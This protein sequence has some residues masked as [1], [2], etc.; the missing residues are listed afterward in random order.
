[1]FKGDIDKESVFYDLILTPLTPRSIGL[2]L[3]FFK[4][5]AGIA[6]RVE[7][8]IERFQ[9]QLNES[10]I[11][12]TVKLTKNI[13]APIKSGISQQS[14][15]NA[16]INIFYLKDKVVEHRVLHERFEALSVLQR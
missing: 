5:G 2:K 6:P 13:N 15:Q 8:D 7:V 10:I 16:H 12:R 11:D 3:H 1:M 4:G 14:S 9:K